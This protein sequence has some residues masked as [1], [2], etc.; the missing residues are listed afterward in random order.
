MKELLFAYG[1][2]RDPHVQKAVFGRTVA[3]EKDELKG[4]NKGLVNSCGRRYPALVPDKNGMIEGLVL[5]VTKGEISQADNYETKAYDRKR[6][7][8]ESGR[9]AW[10]YV[11][12]EK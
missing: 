12:A 8:L 7:T 10:V 5:E 4:Y 6:A 3:S 9:R 1:T 2:L 11:K